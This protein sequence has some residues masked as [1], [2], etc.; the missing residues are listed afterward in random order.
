MP[1]HQALQQLTTIN[2]NA[3]FDAIFLDAFS[4]DVNAEC[5]TTET[6]NTLSKL[7]REGGV[8]A[9][10]CA[11]GSVRRALQAAGLRVERRDGPPGKRECLAAKR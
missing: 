3:R 2:P 1:L 10:Y 5:W 9:T 8:L 7:L 4:P 11:K 6:L